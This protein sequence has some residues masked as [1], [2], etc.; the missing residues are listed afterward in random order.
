[1]TETG[2]E[3]VSNKVKFLGLDY[4]YKYIHF[5]T[6]YSAL[7]FCFTCFIVCKLCFHNKNG[8]SICIYK[9]AN[10]DDGYLN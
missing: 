2:H 10:R 7:H 1:M 3:G 8:L 6:I 4:A 5:V 9:E